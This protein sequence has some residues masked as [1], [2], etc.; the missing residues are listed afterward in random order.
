MDGS[1]FDTRG[2]VLNGPAT[3][4]NLGSDTTLKYTCRCG[5]QSQRLRGAQ[6]T[7]RRPGGVARSPRRS[8]GS[9]ET[10]TGDERATCNCESLSRSRSSFPRRHGRYAAG[11][12]LD[13]RRPLPPPFSVS[14]LCL[15]V[16]VVRK[17]TYI[18][19]ESN[20]ISRKRVRY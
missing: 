17:N 3:T 18:K 19:L 2:E 13:V 20:R 8:R 16:F 14:S 6:R 10:T 5:R 1:R 12:P 4:A 7:Q 15:R 11:R 9:A